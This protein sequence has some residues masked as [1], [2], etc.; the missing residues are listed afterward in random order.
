MSGSLVP[1]VGL[2]KTRNQCHTLLAN[3]LGNLQIADH[4]GINPTLHRA[5]Y[6]GWYSWAV[7][8]ICDWPVNIYRGPSHGDH[9]GTALD[10]PTKPYSDGLR[11]RLDAA[12]QALRDYIGLNI[13][14]KHSFV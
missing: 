6:D 13:E 5:A 3:T 12:R 2:N 14:Y 11:Q 10:M 8:A 7:E 9:G 4:S 1:K